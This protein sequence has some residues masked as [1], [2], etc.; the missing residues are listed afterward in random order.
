MALASLALSGYRTEEFLWIS[1]RLHMG[2]S[3]RVRGMAMVYPKLG[4]IAS[5]VDGAEIP[6]GPLARVP[7]RSSR[8]LESASQSGAKYFER[9]GCSEHDDHVPAWKA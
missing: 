3:P 1:R 8:A 4:Q 7:C 6:C 2:C 9:Y 5:V